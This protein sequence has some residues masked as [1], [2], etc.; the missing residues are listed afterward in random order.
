MN[1]IRI[2]ISV[3]IIYFV[4]S[5]PF[6]CPNLEVNV[7]FY[8]SDINFV[9]TSTVDLC[10]TQCFFMPSCMGFTFLNYT[11][12]CWLKSNTKFM[13]LASNGSIVNEKFFILKYYFAIL[14]FKSGFNK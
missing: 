14:R 9:F 11:G 1:L 4:Q 12:A 3:W 8:G 5:E 7:D 2:F 6:Y 10:C 13:R